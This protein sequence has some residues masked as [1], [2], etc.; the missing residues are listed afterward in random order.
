[1]SPE[2]LQVNCRPAQATDKDGMLELTSRIWDGNDYIPYV[3]DDWLADPDGLLVVAEHNQRIVGLVMLSR[4]SQYDWWMQGMRVHPDFEGRGI[5]SKIHEY[6][7]EIWLTQC[8][9]LDQPGY[10]RLTTSTKRLPIHHLCART[11]FE[12]TGEISC[13]LAPAQ[14]QQEQ[15]RKIFTPL[16]MDEIDAALAWIQSSPSVQLAFGAIDLGW[17]FTPPARPHLEKACQDGKLWRWQDG[18]GL[19]ATWDDDE[20]HS[21]PPNLMLQF[22]AVEMVDLPAALSDFRSMAAHQG[23]PNA[24]WLAPIKPEILSALGQAGYQNAWDHNLLLFTRSSAA[25]S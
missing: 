8:Q 5:A 3:W 17:V 24:G 20:D 2:R 15:M 11:G 18:R 7:L 21:Q 4:L 23:R 13:Y 14:N 6:Q 22:L 12:K 10:L 9:K 25:T 19:L 1:M 16:P